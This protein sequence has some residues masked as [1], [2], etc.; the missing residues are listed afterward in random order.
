MDAGL[1]RGG[2]HA[3]HEGDLPVH[4]FGLMA[5][6]DPLVAIAERHGL[7]VV[8]DAARPTAR[9]TAAAGP[10]SSGRR[11]S[12]CTRTKNLTTGEGGFVTTDDDR[13]ADWLRLYRNH[14]MRVR[15]HHDELGYNF[16]PTDLA[17]AIGLA[18]LDRLDERTEQRRRNAARLRRRPSP[19]TGRPP[20]CP[21]GR[22]ARLA[23]V[24]DARPRRA[25]ARDRRPDASAGIGTAASTTRSRSTGRPTCRRTCRAPP[26][27]TCRSR[28]GSPTRCSRSRSGRTWRRTSSRP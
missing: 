12:A 11:C 8:E 25:R 13:L 20:A 10:A 2:D 9:R 3:A 15:Y 19:A 22:D 6:M 7:A 27:S 5:D 21:E 28:T 18:Q 26:T 17:A 23:P 4:L 24:H 14:G 16:Q 1:D